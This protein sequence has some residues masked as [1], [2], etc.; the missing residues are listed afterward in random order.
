MCCSDFGG[1]KN[2]NGIARFSRPQIMTSG[3]A[4]K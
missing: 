2:V 4:S 3:E 1:A